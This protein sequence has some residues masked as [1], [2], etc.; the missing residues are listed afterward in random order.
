YGGYTINIDRDFLDVSSTVRR[1]QGCP[2]TLNF[3][4]YPVLRAG[5]RGPEVMGAQCLLARRGFD[6]GRATGTVRWRTAAAIKAFNASRGL[7]DRAVV[8]RR[9]W[10]ALLSSGTRPSLQRGS[11]G[12]AVSRLQ[13]GLSASL[14]RTVVV[15]G[16]KTFDRRTR[17]AV[18]VYQR[19]H[20]LTVDGV[21]GK[22]TW[23][24]LQ[25]GR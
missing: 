16:D 15:T 1:P 20:G 22:R 8:G 18:V 11:V 9:T 17:R 5:T 25:A 19:A 21:A 2:T 3:A 23:R 10:T 14:E 24:A 6:P 13:R 7:R 4:T 12:R